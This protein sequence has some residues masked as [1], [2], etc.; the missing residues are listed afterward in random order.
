MALLANTNN[1]IET[2]GS[3]NPIPF[4]EF[5]VSPDKVSNRYINNPSKI[6]FNIMFKR[7]NTNWVCLVLNKKTAINDSAADAKNKIIY[8]SESK[9]YS[10]FEPTAVKDSTWDSP[11]EHMADNNKYTV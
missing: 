4:S 5:A 2:I 7:P 3:S 6:K 11:P 10:T 9:A 1:T 8:S